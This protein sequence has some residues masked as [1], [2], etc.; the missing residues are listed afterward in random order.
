[1]V[2]VL[3]LLNSRPSVARLLL[4]LVAAG[5]C[6]DARFDGA[7]NGAT[8]LR[9]DY[10]QVVRLAAPPRRIV[11]LSPATTELLFALGAGPRVVGRTQ[12]D[13]WPDSARLVPSVGAGMQPNL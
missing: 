3:Y 11:S 1:M 6:R 2:P 9:D 13:F 7:P 5:A 8:E 10:G 12:Y 4:A